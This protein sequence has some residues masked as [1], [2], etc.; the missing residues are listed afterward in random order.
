[1]KGSGAW[2]WCRCNTGK[3]SARR[4]AAACCGLSHGR[5]ARAQTHTHTGRPRLPG[6]TVDGHDIHVL[7]VEG[8][9]QHQAPDAAEACAANNADHQQPACGLRLPEARQRAS[10]PNSPPPQLPQRVPAAHAAPQAPAR[11]PDQLCAPVLDTVGFRCARPASA[12]ARPRPAR[13]V[14]ADLDIVGGAHHH[15]CAAGGPAAGHHR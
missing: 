7:A 15:G 8:G 5:A 12:P 3:A 11:H 13:T 2:V 1:M 9:A 14:D 6:L 10:P 4:A